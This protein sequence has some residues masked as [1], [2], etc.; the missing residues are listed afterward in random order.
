[1]NRPWSSFQI[2]PPLS[3]PENM[4]RDLDLMRAAERGESH[5]RV[6]TWTGPWISLGRFQSPDRDLL[7]PELVPWVMRPTGGKAVL[8]GHDLTIGLA[9][10]LEDGEYRRLKSAYRRV[11]EPVV[12]S[13]RAC[14]M[15][16]LL[17]EDSRV[18][19]SEHSS[20]DCFLG[21]AANDVVHEQTGQKV[22][23]CALRFTR[24]A[25]L[26]QASI[27]VQSPLVEPSR[28][29]AAAHSFAPA[30]WEHDR[31][32]EELRRNLTRTLISSRSD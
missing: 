29:F 2:D 8:H 20:A 12:A 30:Q 27:P 23:G 13:L 24:A 1:M 17:G 21:V 25:V 22:C 6:Y 32:T 15:P 10:P 16:A 14:G 11:I 28:V 4:S 26:L 19:N 5:A 3:G 31:F 18:A 7:D 9:I